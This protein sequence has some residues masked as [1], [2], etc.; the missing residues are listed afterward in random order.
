[1]SDLPFAFSSFSGASLEVTPLH[2]FSVTE[3]Y[4]IKAIKNGQSN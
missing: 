3:D 1:M 4:I 2:L